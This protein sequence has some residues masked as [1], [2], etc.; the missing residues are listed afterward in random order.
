MPAEVLGRD[1]PSAILRLKFIGN[2]GCSF[3]DVTLG[4]RLLEGMLVASRVAGRAGR[5][6]TLD[7]AERLRKTGC[8]GVR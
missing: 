4:I 7:A 6:T 2:G 5:F 1:A 8:E 3:R